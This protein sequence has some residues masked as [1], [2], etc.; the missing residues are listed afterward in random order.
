[1]DAILTDDLPERPHWVSQMRAPIRALL[2]RALRRGWQDFVFPLR[3]GAV[4]CAGL[5]AGRLCHAGW[6]IYSQLPAKGHGE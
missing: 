4:L 5:C 2:G 3:S 6:H 1:M